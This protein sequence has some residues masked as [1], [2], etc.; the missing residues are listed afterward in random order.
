MRGKVAKQIRKD[1]NKVSREKDIPYRNWFHE[2]Y[3]R[4][5]PVFDSLNNY[6]GLKSYQVVT[7]T[8]VECER[9]IYQIAKKNYIKLGYI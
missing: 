5:Y 2:E 1:V 8:L 6:L 9:K 7:S 3:T 4:Q